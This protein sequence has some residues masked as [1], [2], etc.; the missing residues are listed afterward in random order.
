[1]HNVL[2][3][4]GPSSNNHEVTIITFIFM[5]FKPVNKKLETIFDIFN[6]WRVHSLEH[7]LAE[8][9]IFKDE[10]AGLQV[11]CSQLGRGSIGCL[12]GRL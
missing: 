6:D 11:V 1:M 3:P 2:K 9:P 8:D 10:V 5:F 7:F 4:T 12:L